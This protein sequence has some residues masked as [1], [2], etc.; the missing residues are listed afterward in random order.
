MIW[1]N[2][3]HYTLRRSEILTLEM[4]INKINNKKESDYI[5]GDSDDYDITFRAPPYTS[6]TRGFYRSLHACDMHKTIGLKPWF[7]A[8][9]FVHL[10][11]MRY[12]I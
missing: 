1:G 4:K 12:L 6:P 9:S 7:C 3:E 2:N 10:L 8:H 11:P 5:Y